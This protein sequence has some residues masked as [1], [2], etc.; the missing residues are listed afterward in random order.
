MDSD[1]ALHVGTLSINACTDDVDV[2][3]AAE[4]KDGPFDFWFDVIAS[5]LKISLLQL[6]TK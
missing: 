5:F 1:W 2:A 6:L 3:I 4:K